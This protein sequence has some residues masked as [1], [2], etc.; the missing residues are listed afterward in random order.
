MFA[1]CLILFLLSLYLLLLDLFLYLLLPPQSGVCSVKNSCLE[2]LLRSW[3]CGLFW[4]IQ[5]HYDNNAGMM[6][7]DNISHDVHFRTFQFYFHYTMNMNMN[8]SLYLFIN[9]NFKSLSFEHLI[10]EDSTIWLKF[11]LKFNLILFY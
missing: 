8:I 6:V 7:V 5:A 4:N 3:R 1:L 10:I 9:D 2:Y 11:N